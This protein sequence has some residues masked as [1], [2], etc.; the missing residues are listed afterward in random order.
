MDEDGNKQLSLEE[1]SDGLEECGLDLS[2]EEI[3]EMFQKLD[4]DG[5]GN[6]SVDEFI[7]AVRVSSAYFIT[8]FFKSQ[9]IK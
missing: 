1:L 6:I 5:S 9:K 3:S 4:A 2:S 8:T 7:V